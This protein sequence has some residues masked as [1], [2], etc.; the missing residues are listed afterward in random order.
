MMDGDDV[1][2]IKHPIKMRR[3]SNLETYVAFAHYLIKLWKKAL[4]RRKEI[5]S[6]V[7]NI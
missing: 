2:K 5:N 4:G 3:E 6:I 1:F 7:L